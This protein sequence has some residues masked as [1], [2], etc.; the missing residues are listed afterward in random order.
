ME[1]YSFQKI[2][3]KWRANVGANSVENF[4]SKKILLFRNVSLSIRKIHMGHVRNYTIG[5]VVADI[6]F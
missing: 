1:R 2:E 4:K 5:D 3:D 6:N